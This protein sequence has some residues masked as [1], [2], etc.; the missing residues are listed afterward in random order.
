MIIHVCNHST[1]YKKEKIYR[2]IYKTF[3]KAKIAILKY[4]ES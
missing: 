1:Q 2:N 3:E 4:I